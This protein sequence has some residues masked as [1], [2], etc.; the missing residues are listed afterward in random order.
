MLFAKKV[1]LETKF[2]VFFK[3]LHKSA[4]EGKWRESC[5]ATISFRYKNVPGYWSL[6]ARRKYRFE[7]ERVVDG[8]M[9]SNTINK[10]A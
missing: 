9:W 3:W 1:D 5:T 2:H 8:K 10:S 7:E 4:E 6:Y